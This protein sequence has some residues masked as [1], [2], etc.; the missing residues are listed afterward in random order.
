MLEQ[1]RL[2]GTDLCQE[3]SGSR[4]SYTSCLSLSLQEFTSFSMS[5][6][7]SVGHGSVTAVNYC[8]THSL[9]CIA[10]TGLALLYCFVVTSRAQCLS[11]LYFAKVTLLVVYQFTFNKTIFKYFCVVYNRGHRRTFD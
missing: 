5:T 4:H 11:S 2:V 9:L 7:T 6:Q 8:A 1:E 3:T 10:G